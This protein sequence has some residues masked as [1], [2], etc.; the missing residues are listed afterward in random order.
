MTWV[1]PGGERR[2]EKRLEIREQKS[3]RKREGKEHGHKEGDELRGAAD[4][5]SGLSTN[6]LFLS[7]F[8]FYLVLFKMD[9]D[10]YFILNLN[11]HG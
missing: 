8:P 7:F 1:K 10:C 6:K 5:P 11:M 4:T 9:L 3:Q 2:G